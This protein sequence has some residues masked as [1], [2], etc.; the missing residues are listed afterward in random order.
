MNA[1]T[2]NKFF[3]AIPP[4]VIKDNAAYVSNVIDKLDVPND[5]KGVLFL[6]TLGA[7]DIT[8]A[9]LKV[10]QSDTE[11]N[12]T[13]LGGT[14]ELVK[15]TTTKPTPTDDNGIVGIYVPMSKWTEQFLQLQATAGNGTAGTYLSAI[16]IF[17]DV[18]L[19]D[20]SDV[21]SLGLTYLDIA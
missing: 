14:P 11:T 4:G 6:A 16:A 3:N 9:V 17:D 2:R 21:S 18:G 12:P 19:T 1:L 10:M 15:D 8:M 5:C 13:T 7:T 20:I